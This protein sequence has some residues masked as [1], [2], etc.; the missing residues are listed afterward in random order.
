VHELLEREP[1]RHPS[2]ESGA[3]TVQNNKLG[4]LSAYSEVDKSSY[5][6]SDQSDN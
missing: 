2:F 3:A 5:K 4:S 6:G 1:S